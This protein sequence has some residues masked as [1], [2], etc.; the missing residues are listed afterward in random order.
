MDIR[1]DGKVALVTGASKGIGKAIAAE[2]AAAGA[3]VMISS[4]KQDQLDAA[5]AAIDGEV[6]AFAA[7]AGEPDQAEACIAA[8]VDR[9]GGVDILVNNA[10]VNPYFGPLLGIDLPALEKTTKVNQTGFLVWTQFAVKAGLGSRPGGAILNVSS[11]GGVSVEPAL[12]WYNVTKAAVIHLSRHLAAEL[13][14]AVRV[15]A[16]LPGIIRTDFSKALWEGAE[17]PLVKHLPMERLGE[18]EDIAKASLFLVSDAAAWIT[19]QTLVVDAGA[20]VAGGL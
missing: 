3:K 18:P 6:A 11:I 9:F 5:A 16:I 10:A 20:A 12:G 8:C 19:G 4:R 15:N 1:L 7:N 14:P 17:E 2:L 13:A